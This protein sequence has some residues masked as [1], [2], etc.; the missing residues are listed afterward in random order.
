[1]AKVERFEDL[2]IW[3]L[4]R[5]LCI[6][7]EVLINTNILSKNKSLAY[8]LQRSSGSVMDN[9][10]E[11][12][13]KE[14]TKEFV[15]FLFHSKASCGEVRSQLYRSSDLGYIEFEKVNLLI[16]KAETIS[17]KTKTF[18]NYLQS[19]GLKGTRHVSEP[20]VEYLTSETRHD[21]PDEFKLTTNIP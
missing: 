17:R 5:Q 12:F 7:I 9:I 14:N 10:A 2:E 6:D 11:G 18:I 20:T 16:N 8:Q 15:T 1:M 13:E 3:Q 4:A 19:S 21:Y